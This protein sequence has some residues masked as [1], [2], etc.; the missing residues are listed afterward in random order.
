MAGEDSKKSGEIGEKITSLLL[1]KIGWK[2][3]LHN[4]S[5]SCNNSKHKNDSGNQ[6]N[7]HGDDI[8]YL[9]NNPFYDETTTVAHISVKNKSDVYDKSKAVINRKF[10]EYIKELEQII[11]CAQYNEE[12]N[13]YIKL[14]HAKANI[15]HIGILVWL[16]NDKEHIN[17]DI[18][19][20]I[21]KSRPNL[22]D[23]IPYY[24]IDAGRANFLLNVVNNLAKRANK[25]KYQFYYPKIGT[26]VLV[27]IDRKGNFIPIELIASDI[28]TAIVTI[29]DSNKFYLYARESFSEL[30]YKNM[31]AYAL[32]FSAGL[33]NEI[34][35]GFPDYNPAKDKYI[36]QK[37]RLFFQKRDEDINPFSYNETILDLL[38]E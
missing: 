34:N 29:G 6:K 38:E 15:Q 2:N 28:I 16:H 12:I 35:I 3:Q 21:E 20:I 27:D 8:I 5:I 13:E 26:S 19:S 33:V 32:N 30:A 36:T 11:Q 7:S 25:G 14:F 22:E 9:Y 37:I 23:N 1:K 18:L 31:V 17:R 10:K 24:I 4:I